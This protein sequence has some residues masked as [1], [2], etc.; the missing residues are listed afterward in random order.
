[1]NACDTLTI[2]C[3]NNK[4][5]TKPI[6]NNN[7]KLLA[8]AFKKTGMAKENEITFKFPKSKGVKN[9]KTS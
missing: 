7:A 3:I 5:V 2:V 6:R 8:I 4:E 1:M 9:E